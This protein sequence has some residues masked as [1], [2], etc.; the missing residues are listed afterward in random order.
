MKDSYLLNY[1]VCILLSI[2]AFSQDLDYR[3]LPEWS[4][5]SH[6]STQYMIYVPK[7]M[8]SGKI[9]PVALFMHGCCGKDYIATE[10][11]EVDPPVRMWHN[12]AADTQKIPTYIISPKTSRGW[13]QHFANLKFVIDSLIHY[14]HAD[15][16]RLYVTG[17]S[18]GG[19]GTWEII[20]Q[21]SGYFAAAIPMGMDLRGDPE[22]VKGIP[23]WANQGETDWFSRGLKEN[24]GRIRAANGDTLNDGSTWVTG[25]NPRYSNFHGV[26]HGVQWDA[27][28][29]QDLTGWA[30]SKINDGN[31]NPVV[32]FTFPGHKQVLL[33]GKPVIVK[34]SAH[35]PD[36]KITKVEI[37]VNGKIIKTLKH[38]PYEISIIPGAG[39]TELSAV[40]Y[41]NG[42]KSSTAEIIMRVDS[43]PVI[44]D[45]ELPY[46]RAGALYETQLHATGNAPFSFSYDYNSVSLPEGLTLSGNGRLKG[47]P[48]K[49][50]NYDIPLI[51][52]DEDGDT[53]RSVFRLRILPARNGEIIVTHAINRYNGLQVISKM[54]PGETPVY[55]GGDE[56][57]FSNTGGF[58]GLTLIKTDARD[59]EESGDDYLSFVVD[60]DAVVYVGYE[61]YDNR[62]S[63]TIPDWLKSWKKTG[64][65]VIAQYRYFDV[66]EKSFPKGKI[67]LPGGDIKKNKVAENYFVLVRSME[68]MGRSPEITSKSLP[69][70]RVGSPYYT[71]INTLYGIGNF[72]WNIISGELPNGIELNADGT[73]SGFPADDSAGTWYFKVTVIDSKRQ[74]DEKTIGFK[75]QE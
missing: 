15:P 72:T 18:M 2:P 6:D 34:V 14:G 68:K 29:T 52:T 27:A 25:V 48:V 26:G 40:A 4:W 19:G 53:T 56:I 5:G 46:S 38:K 3:G 30:Y 31:I 65:E 51:I 10:R 61:K 71:K 66:Y 74:S 67:T 39:D 36:G 8:E 75:V 42:G 50:G 12:F 28:S 54:K 9:Y 21:Y 44:R 69:D 41:D 70:G 59:T 7:N 16:E 63:S 57:N 60:R 22:K 55:N 17:F 13:K 35:D 49:Q 24:I 32:F 43:K 73:L 20:Q 64:R 62:Y 23:I 11:N 1:F 33:P 37:Q 47:V 58:D 45:A